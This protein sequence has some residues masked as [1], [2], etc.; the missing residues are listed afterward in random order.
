MGRKATGRPLR[1]A[2]RAGAQMMR[3][4]GERRDGQKEDPLNGDI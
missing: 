4:A 3:G 2:G 1:Y